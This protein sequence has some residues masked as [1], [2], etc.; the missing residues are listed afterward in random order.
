MEGSCSPLSCKTADE[1]G[2]GELAAK[3]FCAVL[4]EHVSM[5]VMVWMPSLW[6]NSCVRS[7]E[8]SVCSMQKVS[9]RC[10]I[11]GKAK[12]TGDKQMID[13]LCLGHVVM[14]C[15]C[16]RCGCTHLKRGGTFIIWVHVVH[17]ESAQVVYDLCSMCFTGKAD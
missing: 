11:A 2:C 5:H 16:K 17:E 10:R 12:Q 6:W 1:R 4:R 8:V 13:L 7:V 3:L 15:M 14:A 9:A